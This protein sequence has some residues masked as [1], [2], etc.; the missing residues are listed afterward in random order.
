MGVVEYVR[1]R[2]PL[3]ARPAKSRTVVA[4][5]EKR[6]AQGVAQAY[7]NATQNLGIISREP[8]SV[9][10]RRGMIYIQDLFKK[11]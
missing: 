10:G 3:G 9:V 1:Q 5:E 2:K 4:L 11:A 7:Y 6:D 8:G